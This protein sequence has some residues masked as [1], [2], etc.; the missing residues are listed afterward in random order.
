MKTHAKPTM[1]ALLLLTTGLGASTFHLDDEVTGETLN[2]GGA[3]ASSLNYCWIQTSSDYFTNDRS[4]FVGLDTPYNFLWITYAGTVNVGRFQIGQGDDADYNTIEV[5]GTGPESHR[6]RLIVNGWQNCS[7]GVNGGGNTLNVLD[8]ALADFPTLSE[9]DLSHSDG[10]WN[11]KVLVDGTGSELLIPDG[12]IIVGDYTGSRYN[13]FTISNGGYVTCE[14]FFLGR[15]TRN[16]T[17]VT[18]KGSSLAVAR[19][20]TAG[21]CHGDGGNSFNTMTVS[22]GATVSSGENAWVGYNST[23]DKLIVKD[24][25]TSVTVGGDFGV[26]L[27]KGSLL[28]ESGAKVMV[29]G[30]IHLGDTSYHSEG[31]SITIAGSGS[32][33]SCSGDYMHGF[34][35]HATLILDNGGLFKIGG[36]L[37]YVSGN[38]SF[39]TFLRLSGGSMALAGDQTALVNTLIGLNHFQVRDGA[40]GNWVAGTGTNLSVAYYANEGIAK[41]A[42]GIDGLA[43]STVVTGGAPIL[44]DHSLDWADVDLAKAQL[45]WFQSSWYG[46]FYSDMNTYGAWIFHWLHG[47][48]YVTASGDGIAFWDCG[49]GA[50][51]F[52]GAEYYP[53][54]YNYG[55]G[56]WYYYEG[57]TSPNR[58]FW[59]FSTNSEIG[60]ASL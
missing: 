7:V 35:S 54:L 22:D 44:K 25:G 53:Y 5:S 6:A 27:N 39:D 51:W 56:K 15:G 13:D 21:G 55:T 11:N 29:A 30:A 1:C 38:P 19:F 31:C 17:T 10:S 57:G 3:S 36:Q 40:T 43:N 48:Q 49:T 4:V 18:G 32:A 50:W 52:T 28:V 41:A 37:N 20:L 59:D 23:N 24:S 16:T 46:L 8:G 14:Y 2:A 58:T 9:L 45:H 60:E 34:P 12:T 26:G 42:T 47:W 33:L